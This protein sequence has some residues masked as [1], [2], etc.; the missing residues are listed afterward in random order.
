MR[1]LQ[2]ISIIIFII[3][4]AGFVLWRFVIPLPDWFA[5]ITGII[6]LVSIFTTI[7]SSVRSAT[8]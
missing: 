7:F 6:M 4:L 1:K 3:S 8:K 2:V 5:R